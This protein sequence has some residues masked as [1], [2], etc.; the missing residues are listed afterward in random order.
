MIKKSLF[1]LSLLL[2]SSN[3]FAL[4]VELDKPVIAYDEPDKNSNQIHLLIAEPVQLLQEV[5]DYYKAS[6]KFHN[7]MVF[8][9]PKLE[10]GTNLIQPQVNN[11]NV[12]GTD[13]I[14]TALNYL[15]T[16]YVY[17]GNS[18][19]TGVDCSSFAQLIY[20][21]HGISLSRTSRDQFF[22]NG[23]FVEEDELRAGDLVFYGTAP[24]AEDDST[25]SVQHLGI[26]IGDG[27]MIHAST[28]I[29]GVVV[30]GIHDRGF[31][32]LIGFKRIIP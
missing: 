14:A 15:G 30:D 18:L 31:P 13:I 20:A 21:K 3:A 1:I 23:F 32:P 22:N 6:S 17:G 11:S 29:R 12:S 10:I 24:Q 2:F 28:S 8:Y 27:M 5:G 16:P 4:T 19:V 7:N 9:I 25:Y 26:Y